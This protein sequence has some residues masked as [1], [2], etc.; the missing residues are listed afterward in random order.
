MLSGFLIG[1]ILHRLTSSS[2]GRVD[3][4]RN[5]VFR[6]WLRTVPSY[7]CV[8]TPL[9]LI[10]WL[11]PLLSYGDPSFLQYIFSHNLL[12]VNLDF[13]PESWSLS[14]EEWAYVLL[15]LIS[16]TVS[17]FYA[18]RAV[19][20][21]GVSLVLIGL[22]T[23]SFVVL[24]SIESYRTV[25]IYRL[26]SVGWGVVSYFISRT[27]GVR[28]AN[29]TLIGFIAVLSSALLAILRPHLDSLLYFLSEDFSLVIYVIWLSRI[30]ST[31]SRASD[32]LFKTISVYAY[33]LYL[34]HYALVQNV[35][36]RVINRFIWPESSGDLTQHALVNYIFYITFTVI[37]A[38]F[39]RRIV[40]KPIMDFR[41]RRV[42]RL[43]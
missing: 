7:Y 36:V 15:V 12:S 22:L 34:V 3:V 43:D 2:L 11:T 38:W 20:L 41:D 19:F 27:S 9:I 26:D 21:G 18:Q 29:N 39:L 6:R 4:L 17:L 14:V 23:K 35:I 32:Q 10:G 16:L 33:V 40:E 5:F 8:L 30:G 42:P 25:V 1:G 13:Y 37:A 28:L 31:G 24:D